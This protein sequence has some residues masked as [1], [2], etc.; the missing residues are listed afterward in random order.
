MSLLH[1]WALNAS[2]ALLSMQGQK[3]LGFH[4]KY[5]NLCSEDEQ[6]SYGFGTTRGW[7]IN[8]RIFIFGWTI[9]L[10]YISKI[11]VKFHKQKR[12]VIYYKY[13]ELWSRAQ[14]NQ[15]A[16]CYSTQ[17]FAW[18]TCTHCQICVWNSQSHVFLLKWLDF[19]CENSL[20]NGECNQF[21]RIQLTTFWN[22]AKWLH[23]IHFIAF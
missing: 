3:A 15:T 5:L 1:F 4:Q 20:N 9:T 21:F 10:R 18:P 16:F 14:I 13:R 7:V 6:M 23:S 22:K 19:I 17:R 8:D 11:L 12:S 2:V